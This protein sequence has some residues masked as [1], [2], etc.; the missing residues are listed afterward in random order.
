MFGEFYCE[1]CNNTWKSG[2]AWEGTGQQCNMCMEMILPA[3]LRPLRRSGGP[4]GP[5]HR[6]D[7]CGMCK[8]LGHNCRGYNPTDHHDDDDD[9][10]VRSF[11][12]FTTDRS[13]G[14]G[15]DITP[16]ASDDED[17]IS[18]MLATKINKLG[19]K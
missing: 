14:G 3:S 9:Q 15:D 16:T 5:P 6:E 12:S 10:S 1:N 17:T 8:K 18:E 2:N 4:R 13:G 11:G 19:L 7:L